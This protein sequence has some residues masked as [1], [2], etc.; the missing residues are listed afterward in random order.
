MKTKLTIR[1]TIIGIIFGAFIMLIF[2]T[3]CQPKDELAQ[4]NCLCKVITADITPRGSV[5][6]YIDKDGK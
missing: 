3:R 2:L 4:L 5:V 6:T 1:D